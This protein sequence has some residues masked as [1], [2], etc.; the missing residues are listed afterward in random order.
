M[1]ERRPL[2]VAIDGPA[3]VGK[4][5]AAR[6]LA[7]RL[8]VPFVDTGAM[9][10]A[11]GYKA[12]RLGIDPA[13]RSAVARLVEST[14][15]ELVWDPYRAV[16]DVVLDG[17]SVAAAIRSTEVADATSKLAQFPEVRTRMV[18]LQR[19]LAR[20]SGAV[21]EGR[22]IGT[23]VFPDTP[24]KFFLSAPPEVRHERRRQQK[25]KTGEV[26]ELET[27]AR[28]MARRDQRDASR[29][30]SPM[31]C[32]ASYTVIDT[33]RLTQEEVVSALLRSIRER[34]PAAREPTQSD[35]TSPVTRSAN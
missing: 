14:R 26:V 28:E 27:L 29:E 21:M 22:D 30:D 6:Q 8:G 33:S 17:V 2:V 9:Y 24:Y 23:T 5:S 32:D 15:V 35:G 20:D 16:L 12:L 31:R 19:A 4:S 25:L 13:D 7:E 1:K 3:G 11:L 18:E 34:P 10:R